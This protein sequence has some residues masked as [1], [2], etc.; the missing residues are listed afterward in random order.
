MTR[1]RCP[2]DRDDPAAACYTAEPAESSIVNRI[3]AALSADDGIACPPCYAGF[4]SSR[5]TTTADMRPFTTLIALAFCALPLIGLAAGAEPR[6]GIAMH[7]E[8]ALPADF[9][10]LPYAN[11]DAP[12]GGTVS[13]AVQGTFDSLN[14]LIIQGSGAR[15]ILDLVYGNNVFDTLMMRSYDEPFTLYPLL[16]ESIDTDDDRSYAEFTLDARARFS[17]GRPVTPEDVIF[18]FELLRDKG[19]PRYKTTVS[20]LASMEKVGERGVR[21]TFDRPDRE[22]PLILGLMPVLPKHAIDAENF[23]KSTLQPMIGSGPYRIDTVRPGELLV[24]QRNPDYWARDIPSKRGFDNFDEIRLNYFRD[25]NAMFEAFKKG[26]V[27]VFLEGS[28]TRWTSQY[29]FPAVA[30]GDV[31]KDIFDSGLPSGMYGFVM[32]TRRPAF[33]DRAA[34][35]AL[36][37]LFDFEWANQN[38]FSGVYRR[39][40]SFWDGSELGSHGVPANAAEKALL[41]PFPDAVAPEIMAG[42]WAPPVSDGTGRDRGFLRRGF[43]AFKEAGYV[44]RDRKLVGP[45]GQP[46][47]F[48]IMLK[49]NGGQELALAWQRTMAN[50]GIEAAIRSVDAAQYQQRLLTRDYDVILMSYSASLSPGVEQVGRWGSASKDAPGSWN[51]AGVA[52]PAVDAL[53]EALLQARARSDFID[54]VRALDRAL[55]TGAYVVP[56]YHQGEQWVGRWTR[57]EHTG[58]VPLYGYQLPT[59]WRVPN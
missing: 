48:E 40:R 21:F 50:L 35:R 5:Q 41:S 7:G 49:S 36:A 3:C 27:D 43:D 52:D 1:P 16:A 10:H 57:I 19:F 47:A 56:L 20:K 42:T 37:G 2:A 14:P 33:Q 9:G 12:K 8:P 29:D 38:L 11:P 51:F 25:E 54:A 46:F 31:A 15:G 24:L 13:Y 6:H 45:D 17:D 26:L 34:R 30:A 55:L 22:L 32:N 28:S 59:W 39:T 53:I 23:D 58:K 18:T 4:E 44:M